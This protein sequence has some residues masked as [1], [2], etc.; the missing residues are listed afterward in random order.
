M[1][2][3]HQFKQAS[4]W[5]RNF[6]LWPVETMDFRKRT[7]WLRFYWSRLLEN[8]QGKTFVDRSKSPPSAHEFERVLADV[9][10]IQVV[11]VAVCAIMFATIIW[12]LN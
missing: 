6:A 10:A 5:E 7:V 4:E 9:N 1:S 11:S 8:D 2:R 3:A 12:L